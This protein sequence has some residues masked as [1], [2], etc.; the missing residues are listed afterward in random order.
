MENEDIIDDIIQGENSEIMPLQDA[1]D[2]LEIVYIVNAILQKDGNITRTA[3]ELNIS[4]GTI[5]DL[6]EKHGISCNDG[7]LSIK[8]TPLLKYIRLNLP[9]LEQTINITL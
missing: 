8:L 7:I 3:S 9:V 1:R 6:M 5:Y 2:V 4:R